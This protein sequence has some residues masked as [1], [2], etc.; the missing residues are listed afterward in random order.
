MR[1]TST[2]RH[3]SL[4]TLRSGQLGL[5]FYTTERDARSGCWLPVSTRKAAS[6]QQARSIHREEGM[7]MQ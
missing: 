2:A 7:P 4:F 6:S 1:L 5:G 3:S